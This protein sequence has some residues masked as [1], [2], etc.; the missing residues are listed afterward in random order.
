MFVLQDNFFSSA[1]IVTMK[2]V[3][4]CPPNQKDL[5]FIS[6]VIIVLHHPDSDSEEERTNPD[7]NM[8]VNV[9]QDDHQKKTSVSTILVQMM[10][11]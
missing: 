10:V 6:E 11:T 2:P 9:P 3:S 8:E 5:I 4:D 1:G 7:V